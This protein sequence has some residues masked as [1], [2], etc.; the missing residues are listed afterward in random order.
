MN[1]IGASTEFQD[2]IRSPGEAPDVCGGTQS[3]SSAAIPGGAFED[4]VFCRLC[5]AS[6]VVGAPG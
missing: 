5:A 4:E 3:R 1:R 6:V 2:L